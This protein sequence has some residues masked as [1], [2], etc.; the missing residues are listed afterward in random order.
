[1]R[2]VF[3]DYVLDTDRYALHRQGTPVSLA[4]Q[5]FQLL[6]YLLEHRDRMVTKGELHEQVWQSKYIADA[7][8]TTSRPGARRQKVGYFSSLCSSRDNVTN[9]VQRCRQCPS[10]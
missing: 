1:M 3:G 4:P 6:T 10:R 9:G 2:Y 7:A 8:L 5:A